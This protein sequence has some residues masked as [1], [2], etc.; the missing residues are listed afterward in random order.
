ML[1]QFESIVPEENR[2]RF[3]QLTVDRHLFGFTLT[4]EWGR[5]ACYKRRRSIECESLDDLQKTIIS[6]IKRR[7]A[8]R[9]R[10]TKAHVLEQYLQLEQWPFLAA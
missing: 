1:L 3:Y 9:Y 8:H 2:F 7:M 4:I 6:L 5:I 10:L